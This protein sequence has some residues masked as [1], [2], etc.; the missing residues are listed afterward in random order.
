[1]VRLTCTK[2]AGEG[3]IYKSQFGGNDP[4]VWPAGK[5]DAC[6]GGGNEPCANHGCKDDAVAFNDDGEAMCQD[7]LMS[8]TMNY[9]EDRP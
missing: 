1:M 2:C 8:W 6:D 7:C 5:C 4:D 9:A 3:H